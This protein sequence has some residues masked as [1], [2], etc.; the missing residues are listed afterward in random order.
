[1]KPNITIYSKTGPEETKKL[2]GYVEAAFWV[3]V[4]HAENDLDTVK[5]RVPT[6]SY[7]QDVASVLEFTSLLVRR[8]INFAV[9]FFAEPV[10]GP[11]PKEAERG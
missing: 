3:G 8:Q 1:M 9:E 6:E 11:P 7:D 10:A 4:D 5:L 2:D